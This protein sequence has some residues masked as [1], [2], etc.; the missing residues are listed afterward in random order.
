M[1]RAFQLG[2]LRGIVHSV[3]AGDNGSSDARGDGHQHADHPASAPNAVGC[4]GTRL[5]AEGGRRL[6]EEAWNE[7]HAG[8]GATGGGVSTHFAIPR[9]QAIAGIRPVSADTGVEGR[10]LPDVA[11][12]AD[13]LTGYVIHHCGVDAV[14]GG[15]SAVA[16]LWTALFAL[17]SA[18]TDHRLGNV[19][20]V[21]YASRD[22]AF[23]DISAGDNGA[24]AAHAGWDAATGLGVPS[25]RALRA[26]LALPAVHRVRA[27]HHRVLAIRELS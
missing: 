7:L 21:L 25:G 1:D 18:S 12:N 24:Y 26:S 22:R 16:P 3:A 13:P 6:R 10:G 23:T 2:A 14:V 19:L 4:G 20:P 27:S 17:I 11:G 9:Y 15:T 5:F 8:Q